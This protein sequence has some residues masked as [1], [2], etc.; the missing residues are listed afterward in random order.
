MVCSSYD[1]VLAVNVV[2]SHLPD[3]TIITHFINPEGEKM[4]HLDSGALVKMGPTWSRHSEEWNLIFGFSLTDN[5]RFNKEDL[6]PRIRLLLKLP[7]LQ[8][9]VLHVSH[10]VIE[11]VVADKYSNG[12]RVF[13]AGDACHKRPPTTGKSRGILL[14]FLPEMC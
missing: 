9:E 8:M 1:V 3:R 11:R 12:N 14:L 7:D 13:L 2:L 6:P 4:A 5:N 10:W